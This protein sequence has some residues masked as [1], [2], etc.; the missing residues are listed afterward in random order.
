MWIGAYDFESA[1][2][3]DVQ[4]SVASGWMWS[5]GTPYNYVNTA[6]GKFIN[7]VFFENKVKST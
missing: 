4:E 1:T 7:C 6:S 5:D 3:I 2:G